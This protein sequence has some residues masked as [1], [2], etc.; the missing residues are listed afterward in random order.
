MA[1]AKE[2]NKLAKSKAEIMRA[3]YNKRKEQGMTEFKKW[4]FKH[5]REILE[6]KYQEL[7]ELRDKD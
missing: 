6:E 1:P 3:L 5:E 4:V 2:I 7:E